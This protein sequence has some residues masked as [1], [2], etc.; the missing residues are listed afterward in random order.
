MSDGRKQGT[1]IT[2]I[3]GSGKS[4]FIANAMSPWDPAPKVGHDQQSETSE[5]QEFT[6]GEPIKGFDVI[7]VDTPGFDDTTH[8]NALAFT[9]TTKWLKEFHRA[10]KFLSGIIYLYDINNK[11][12]GGSAVES[13]NIVK[14]FCGETFTP[15]VM[16][17]S[18]MWSTPEKSREISRERTLESSDRYWASFRKNGAKMCRYHS[19]DCH[20]FEEGA[21][22]PSEAEIKAMAKSKE[23]ARKEARDIIL[24]ILKNPRRNTRFQHQVINEGKDIAETDVCRTVINQLVAAVIKEDEKEKEAE[25]AAKERKESDPEGSAFFYEQAE[26]ARRR[27]E[28][29][30]QQ[31]L[32]LAEFVEKLGYTLAAVAEEYGYVVGSCGLRALT[33]ITANRLRAHP[34]DSNQ[35]G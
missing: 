24:E 16:L 4:T 28:R 22:P 20:P 21:P 6:I 15:S 18:N 3:T 11:R 1:P 7:L 31:W 32:L 8:G 33:K 5:I 10:N 12:G 17:V 13:L 19:H 23:E 9:Q 26:Q 34:P 35:L 25:A 30:Q 2:G 14:K 27:K 29:I